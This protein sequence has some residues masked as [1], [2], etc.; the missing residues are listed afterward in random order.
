MTHERAIPTA[1]KFEL[2]STDT[3]HN[4]TGY[5]AVW[6]SES[7]PLPYTETVA[8]GAFARSLSQPPNGRQTLV[9]DHDDSKLLASTRTQRLRLSEDGTGLL[10]DAD[11]ADTSYARDLR[12]LDAAG[13]LGGM[14]FEFSATKGGAPFSADGKK[15]TLREVRL[16]H[17]TA[18]TGKTP[19]YA[20]TTASVRAL[21]MQTGA[22]FEDVSLVLEAVREGRRMAPDEWNLLQRISAS[23][24]PE[25]IAARWSS[26]AEDASSASYILASLLGLL[27]DETD[28]P[29]QSA[30]LNAAITEV[31]AFIASETGEIGTAEDVT[32]SGM[33]MNA[34]PNLDAA[35]ALLGVTA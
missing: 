3:G 5:A 8:P 20:T 9:V 12:E 17:V 15:R 30:H 33:T 28:D 32:D 1:G 22:D 2:R 25:A 29:E 19:A 6:G 7:A 23:V 21:S 31:Q 16:Y 27:A 26:A 13:E 11:M 14:S 35:R 4:F 18:L 34:H 24:A 10:V